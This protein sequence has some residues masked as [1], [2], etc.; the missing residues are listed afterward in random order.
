MFFLNW[1]QFVFGPDY[2]ILGIEYA[3]TKFSPLANG[4]DI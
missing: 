3:I 4:S 2:E 1:K